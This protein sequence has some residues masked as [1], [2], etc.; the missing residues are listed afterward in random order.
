M[1]AAPDTLAEVALAFCQ[2]CL[3]W[4]MVV[5]QPEGLYR[6]MAD[7]ITGLPFHY[8]DL[9]SVMNA[10]RGWC[11]DRGLFIST[12]IMPVLNR[13]SVN[14]FDHAISCETEETDFG[15]ALLLACVKSAEKV[16]SP[17]RPVAS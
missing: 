11:G 2:K 5:W 6:G 16:N 8:T 7:G 13:V 1:T 15:H 14:V 17:S 3:G 4:E 12:C 10:A 9:N